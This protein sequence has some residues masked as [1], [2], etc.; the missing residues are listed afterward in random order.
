MKLTLSWIVARPVVRCIRYFSGAISGNLSNVAFFFRSKTM[1]YDGKRSKIVA[2]T[3]YG[4][5][6]RARRGRAA[7]RKS[8]GTINAHCILSIADVTF[9]D[10]S[11]IPRVVLVLETLLLKPTLSSYG[12]H[13]SD[14]SFLK[15]R[16]FNGKMGISLLNF[17][18]FQPSFY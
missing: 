10:C 14:F 1:Q 16:Y 18:T 5:T 8:I 17:T 3:Y 9:T 7:V 11:F 13:V 2:I 4:S 6:T 12:Y 15:Q